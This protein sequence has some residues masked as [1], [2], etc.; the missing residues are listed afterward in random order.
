MAVQAEL[1]ALDALGPAGAY[2]TRQRQTI[3]DV[4]GDPLAELSL[5][6][7]LFVTR[8]MAALRQAEALPVDERVAA[9]ACAGE[10]YLTGTVDGLPL[11]DQELMVSRATGLPI[12]IVREA[13]Q[14][15]ARSAAEVYRTT[16]VARPTG[17]VN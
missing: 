6:P 13:S 12:S 10:L 17:A 11:V 2:H 7:R 5:V 15:I 9:I 16:Q 4:A 14:M 3:S 8:T 1:L